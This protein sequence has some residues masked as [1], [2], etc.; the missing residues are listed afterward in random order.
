LQRALRIQAGGGGWGCHGGS[1]SQ[2]G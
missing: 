2:R 1:I